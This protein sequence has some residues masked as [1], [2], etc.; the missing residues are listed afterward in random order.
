MPI[1]RPRKFTFFPFLILFKRIE[2][3]DMTPCVISFLV[4][5]LFIQ[6][7]KRVTRL[8]VIA[9]LHWGPLCK[10]IYIYTSNMITPSHREKLKE[11]HNKQQQISFWT[12]LHVLGV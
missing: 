12:Q 8:A 11:H 5:Y 10:H 6:C 1:F 2:S 7:F 9:I 4:I 3:I